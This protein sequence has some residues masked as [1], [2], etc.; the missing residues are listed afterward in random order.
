MRAGVTTGPEL[1]A[2]V[3]A[4]AARRGLPVEQFVRPLI[5]RGCASKW[6]T[7]VGRARHPLANT[8]ARVRDLVEGRPIAP[9]RSYLKQ[10]SAGRVIASDGSIPEPVDRDPCFRCGVR[11]DIGCRHR[12]ARDGGGA[13]GL[14]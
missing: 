4:A 11:G 6:L 2:I 5:G 14:R 8:I 12:P 7:D 13:I 10:P 3:R 9:A 1:V